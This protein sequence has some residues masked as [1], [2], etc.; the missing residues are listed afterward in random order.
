MGGK[1]KVGVF[2]DA[3]NLPARTV[4]RILD[5]AAD[6]GRIVERRVY[7][8][9]TKEALNSWV[10]MA[11][12]YALSLQTSPAALAG[13]NSSDIMLAVDV[14][15]IMASGRLDTFCI[16]T[17]DSDFVHLANRLRMRGYRAIGI[18]GGKA[19]ETLRHAYDVFEELHLENAGKPHLSP[20]TVKA[21]PSC[22]PAKV[23]SAAATVVALPRAGDIR[24]YIMQ[25]H[26]SMSIA[27]GEWIDVSRLCSAIC[28]LNP[29]FDIKKF[30]SSKFSTVLK[31]CS[32]LEVGMDGAKTMRL[33][34]KIQE[35]PSNLAMRGELG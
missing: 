22:A 19:T 21:P 9:F 4:G 1:G 11:A 26:A 16:A 12:R 30:G 3:E 10:A 2:I 8:D 13:K 28:A 6:C 27:P 15:E 20:A 23:Q 35:L 24:P 18:G 5:I 7:G 33:R 32:F 29:G 14:T 25:A 17:S 31:G 34:M